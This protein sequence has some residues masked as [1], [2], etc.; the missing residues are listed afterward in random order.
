MRAPGERL[1]A[2]LLR[3]YP[4]AFRETY[5]DDLLA[6]FRHDR[7]HPRYGS[8]PLRPLRFWIATIRDLARAVR[9]QRRGRVDRTGQPRAA[10]TRRTGW[11]SRLAGDVRHAWRGLRATPGVTTSALAVLTLGIGAG[12]AI[13]SV[14]DAV[15]LRGLPFPDNDRLVAVQETSLPDDGSPMAAAWPNYA[16]WRARQRVFEM[17][18]ATARAG[19]FTTTGDGSAE[20]LAALRVTSSLFDLLPVAP[21]LGRPFRPSD[22]VAGAPAVVIITD[23]VWRRRFG[24]RPDVVGQ[25]MRFENGAR[26]IVGVL[27]RGFVYPIGSVAVSEI[28]VWVPYVASARDTARDGGRTYNLTVVARLRAGVSVD[29][30]DHQMRQVRDG[31]AAEHP[32]WF[33]DIGIV[34]RPLQ[35]AIVNE[36]VRAWMLMLLAAVGGVLLVACLN[37]ANLLLARALARSREVALR[38][39][40]GA[41]R[42][43][44]ARGLVVESL[45]LSIAG[46][47]A[48]VLL[49][50]WLVDVLRAT[51]PEQLPRLSSIAVD[52]RVLGVTGLVT[53]TTGVVFG[54]LPAL[55]ISRT[56]VAG[57][58]RQGGR[59]ATGGGAGR[60]LRIGLVVAEVAV[61]VVL[62]AG[63]GL[64]AASFAR[65]VSVDLGVN[66]KGV[67][68]LGLAPR[69]PRTGSAE[70]WRAAS[71]DAIVGALDRVRA[72]PGVVA[73]TAIGGGLPLSGSSMSVPVRVP[74][75]DAPF[76]GDDMPFVHGATEDYVTVMGA[77]LERGRWFTGAD[78]R[79]APRV[80]VVSDEAARRFFGGAGPLGRTLTLDEDD[81]PLTVVGVVRAIRHSGPESDVRPQ[82]FVPYVQSDQPGGTIVVRAATSEAALVPRLQE[83]IRAAIPT[84]LLYEPQTLER[85]FGR[86]VAQRRFNMVVIG[87]FGGLALLIAAV[88]IYGLMAFLVAQRTREIGVRLALGA[89]PR[90]VRRLVLAQ[91]V[92]L[93]GAGLVVGLGAAASLER[94]VRAFLYD[95][96]PHDPAVYLAVAAVLATVGVLAAMGPARRAAR[97]D[98]MITLRAE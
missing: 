72:V 41:S 95:A 55:P 4:R 78:S 3:L 87:L 68:S 8:G 30:A 56:D 50:F 73:A 38:S 69:L 94:L 74:G 34:V 98:P 25:V 46:A 47:A 40:L 37:V 96:R 89:A 16:D 70:A 29:E 49:A 71:Q 76:S 91:A 82:V 48:G 63:A 53:V 92:R 85:H 54:T 80:A 17:M 2:L 22:E 75:R 35:D 24:A 33:E 5:A 27:P 11:G 62:L 39:A 19:P 58:L 15:A 23:E 12:T 90:G 10:R 9:A 65:V 60:R 67:L 18:A 1:F 32:R 44:L 64:F 21:A 57:L 83:A 81:T 93:I 7:A 42:M 13:F 6:F 79:G 43:D 20:T 52:L 77:T 66:P 45:M 51:L 59:S 14:V 26:E 31:L 28:D 84:A 61:A 88:G 36:R 97:V 86:L